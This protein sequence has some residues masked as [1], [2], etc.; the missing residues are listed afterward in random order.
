MYVSFTNRCQNNALL[1]AK[2]TQQIQRMTPPPPKSGRPKTFKP[3]T[4]V[5]NKFGKVKSLDRLNGIDKHIYEVI[6]IKLA[7]YSNQIKQRP[8]REDLKC[9]CHWQG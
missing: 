5:L 6:L 7:R 2:G 8:W 9:E 1:N 3:S 4:W